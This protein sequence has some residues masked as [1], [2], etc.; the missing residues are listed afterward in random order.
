MLRRDFLIHS[1]V[2]SAETSA[3][4]TATL[5][6]AELSPLRVMF[7]GGSLPSVTSELE[8]RVKLQVLVAGQDPK[9][10]GNA[11]DNFFGLEQLKEAD[12][13]IGSDN[14]RNFPSPD[15]LSHFQDYWQRASHSLAIGPRA[16]F[17][18]TGSRSIKKCRAS[19]MAGIICST[20][21]PS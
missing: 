1:V 15:Q 8:K 7:C 19:S 10:Q 14:K 9:K 4:A 16:I 2:C 13:W 18:K 20:R 11:E 5:M 6:G 12:L 3:L 17:F 21:I